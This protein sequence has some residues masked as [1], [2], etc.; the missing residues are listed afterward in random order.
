M[1]AQQNLYQSILQNLALVPMEYL[2]Q[3]DDYLQTIIRQNIQ[4]EA[5]RQAILA[6]AGSWNDMSEQEFREDIK[7]NHKS[8]IG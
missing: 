5:N 2:R 8:I 1:N 6:L 3:V 4:K 7:T